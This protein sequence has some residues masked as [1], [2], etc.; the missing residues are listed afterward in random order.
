MDEGERG[1][2]L[3]ALDDRGLRDLANFSECPI[4]QFER[5]SA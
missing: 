2:E 3:F 1:T 5:G 4:R